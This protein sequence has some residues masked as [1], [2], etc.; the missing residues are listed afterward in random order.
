MDNSIFEIENLLMD[1][2]FINYC[3]NT[4]DNDVV[5]WQNIIKENPLLKDNLEKA[6]KICF[7]LGVKIT[8]DEKAVQFQ[9][10]RAAINALDEQE[11]T[12]VKVKKPLL[13]KVW[14][15]SSVAAAVLLLFVGIYFTR[16]NHSAPQGIVLYEQVRNSSYRVIAETNSDERKK[17]QLSDGTIVTM[18]GSSVLKIADD[19]NKKDRNVYLTG[20][21][22][23]QVEK[24]HAKP[25]TVI[26]EKTTTTALGT[27]F[28][29]R[30]YQ[31]ES[32]ENIMLEK[33][34]V[35]V[36]STHSKNI[37][38]VILTP[39][40]QATLSDGQL[41]FRKS[42]FD[43]AAMNTWLQRRLVFSN[44]DINDITEKFKEIYGINII[45]SKLAAKKISFTGE[46]SDENPIKVIDAIAFA[47]HFTYKQDKN[48]IT[49]F[50]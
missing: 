5:R 36:Q 25:F 17:V 46:F 6:K 24:N 28:K 34:K 37:K 14:I 18:N 31:S 2:S 32:T 40:E 3:F 1:E 23:F 48:N 4:N 22:F 29:V 10:L 50:F 35:K 44:S 20:E 27:E 7:L 33:G 11:E 42:S 19:Y 8:D 26:T 47:N 15:W 21:A 16:Q 9:K 49:L 43:T 30:S 39:G 41:S 13:K 38:N 45:I 12:P